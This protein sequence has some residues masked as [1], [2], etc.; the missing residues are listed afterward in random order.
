MPTRN[1][2]K[3]SFSNLLEIFSAPSLL[4]P[5][6]TTIAFDLTIRNSLFPGLPGQT[7][8]VNDPS[9]ARPNPRE[10]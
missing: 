10:G 8:P 7:S 6:Q 4:R 3:S 1:S 2:P 9:S 5:Y